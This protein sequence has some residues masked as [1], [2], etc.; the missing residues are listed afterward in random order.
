MVLR[1]AMLIYFCLCQWSALANVTLTARAGVSYERQEYIN[2]VL[3]AALNANQ[4]NGKIVSVTPIPTRIG[5]NASTFLVAKNEV[6]VTYFPAD[7]EVEKSLSAI[8]IPLYKGLMGYRTLLIRK[9]SQKEF[10]QLSSLDE[11]KALLKGTGTRWKSTQV[12]DF[13][14]FDYVTADRMSSLY[15]MLDVGKFDYTSRGVIEAVADLKAIKNRFTSLKIE[16]NIL[17]YTELPIYFFVAQNKP[18]LAEKIYLGLLKIIEN[19]Q[20]DTLFSKFYATIPAELNLK[21]RKIYHVE[22]PFLSKETLE[23]AQTFWQQKI[24]KPAF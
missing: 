2:N 9:T 14:E 12:Y 4:L 5:Y 6:D 21:S 13:H 15:K 10:A 7:K 20:F 3:V 19:G 16:D 23:N 8:R 22:N 11:L 18:E 24:K 1:I 17:L